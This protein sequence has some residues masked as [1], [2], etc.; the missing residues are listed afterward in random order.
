MLKLLGERKELLAGSLDFPAVEDFIKL[1]YIR[2]YGQRLD[3][4]YELRTDFARYVE[5]DGY[6]FRDFLIVRKS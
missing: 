3:M 2:L 4:K 6:R 5:K 1:I